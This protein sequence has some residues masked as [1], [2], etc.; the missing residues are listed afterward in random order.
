MKQA[1]ALAF[2]LKVVLPAIFMAR[3]Y[4]ENVSEF[5]VVSINNGMNEGIASTA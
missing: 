4:A 2:P 3:E 5:R 1:G